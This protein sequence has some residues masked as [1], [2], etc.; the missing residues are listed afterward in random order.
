MQRTVTRLIMFVL[1]ALCAGTLADVEGD[2]LFPSPSTTTDPKQ[3]IESPDGWYGLLRRNLGHMLERRTEGIRTEKEAQNLDLESW[4]RETVKLCAEK[5]KSITTASN[6]AGVAGCW[7][8]PLLVESTGVFAAD[9]RLFRVAEPTGDWKNVDVS[10]YNISVEYDGS[11]AI[12]A[13]NMTDKERKASKEGMEGSK[14]TKLVDSQFI[15]N[16]DRSVVTEDLSE[17]VSS[18]VLLH[19]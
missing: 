5:L 10:S 12:Q 17:Y 18:L 16:L 7:N 6:P 3:A 9:L 19:E 1:L 14:L 4:S 13:R 8:L 15:G 2:S 11:A